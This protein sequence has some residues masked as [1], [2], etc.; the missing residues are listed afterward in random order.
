[1]KISYILLCI[2][3]MA[4]VTYLIRAVPMVVFRKKIENRWIQS[5]LYYVPYVVLAA[6]TFP[7]VFS[8][9]GSH[10]SAIIGT[11][12]AV[13]LAFFRRGLLTVATGAALAAFIVQVAGI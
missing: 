7:A 6:M 1:M 13:V 10:I 12:L 8:S 3:V 11:G 5:F 9:T 4:S 2:A